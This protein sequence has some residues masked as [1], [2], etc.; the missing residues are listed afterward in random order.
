MAGPI[1]DMV[2]GK[3]SEHA[4]KEVILILNVGDKVEVS[5]STLRLL[6]SF[7]EDVDQNPKFQYN[8]LVQEWVSLIQYL[9]YGIEDVV[10]EY[11]LRVDRLRWKYSL[12]CI[13]NLPTRILARYQLTKSLQRINRNLQEM[14]KYASMLD[15]QSIPSSS[16]SPIKNTNLTLRDDVA[17][18]VF[19]F[20]HD[21]QVITDQLCDLHVARRAV[22]SIVGMGG[23]GKT[24][25]A[26]KVYNS[27]AVKDHF[28]CRAWIV[29]S[30][31]YTAREILTNIM[32]QTTNIES[33]QIWEMDEAE[34]KNKIK[35][36]LKRTRFLVVMD[37]IWKVSDWETIKTAFPEEYTASRV[38]LTT[39]KMDVAETADPD[40]PPHHLKLLESEE[41]W[42]LF[43]KNAFSN[44]CCPPH[45]QHFQ[46]K[47]IQKCGGLPLAI[48]VL[49]GLLRRKHE[50]HEWSQTLE[51]ISHAPN[52][53]D[54][55][56]HK[57]LALSYND[58]PHHLKSCFLYFAAFPED[59]DIDADRLMRLWIAE[60]F[61]GSDL[62]GRTMEDLAEMYLIEL[63]SRCMIQVGRRNL[64]RGVGSV[65]IHDLLLDLARHEARKL[66]FCISIW[67]K[68]DSTD[69]RRLSITDDVGV[70]LYTSLGL[71]I[72]KL[73]SLLFHLTYDV[74]M[75]SKSMIRGFKFLRVLDLLRVYIESLPSE[76][77]DLIL[78]RYL[79]L[80][81]SH[82]KEL[83]STIGNLCHLQTFIL[84]GDEFTIPDSFWK[85][86]TLRHFMVD[87]P[88]EPKAGC[89]LKDMHTMCE[90]QSGKWVGDGSL[91]RM[92][93]LRRLGLYKIS[94][95]DSKG[96]DNA[97]GRLNRLVWLEMRGHALPANILCSSN[98]P[99]LRYLDLRGPL[100]RL[101]TDNIHHDAPFL[102]NLASLNLAMTRL[103][104]D[105]VSSILAKLPN[106][107]RLT[108]K[109][110]AVVGSVLVFPKGGFPRLQYLSLGTL[111]D[112][113]EWRVEEGAMPCLRELRLWDCDNLRM[114]PEGLRR[115][116]QLKLFKLIG[117]PVIE[118][119]IEKDNGE[120]YYKIQHVPSIKIKD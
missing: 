74:D 111:Q 72:P 36:H 12:K 43:C 94:S 3:M 112:L 101:H 34:M 55:Q 59:D 17:D 15:I 9:A 2:L 98:H 18:E 45:L 29:V 83:P 120:D 39:R 119:R 8:K 76:I 114:L 96:L 77:G 14:P 82:V 27:Q 49:A 78:L 87:S 47:I 13:G 25:L 63:I 21:I 65:R 110:E 58:L 1:V 99:H 32:K 48:V 92:R 40:S 62:E 6:L 42:T 64:I 70:L 50:A 30:Q 81:L 90:V 80:S 46:D 37:D 67:D 26:N 116:T 16:L 105:D 93:N 20:D 84:V 11:T 38:L 23:S 52:K 24:T 95:S 19:G 75:P 107:E 51:R 117:M 104:S 85:I 35:K 109:Y 71:S 68:G 88:I 33:N 103:E 113:E 91:E 28:Q 5:M 7:L 56:T 10:D 54:D 44:A 73:R 31:S 61:V 106:L 57:I 69:V 86:Q 108:L 89:C 118:R 115:L 79:A 53:T 100:E 41:S 102:P 22:I 4:F 97:L 66:N 60:G